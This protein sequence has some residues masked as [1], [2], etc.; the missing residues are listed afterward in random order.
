MPS[1]EHIMALWRLH[2]PE[3][4][5]RL[6]AKYFQNAADWFCYGKIQKTFDHCL[7]LSY[8]K[9][10]DRPG[11]SYYRNAYSERHDVLVIDDPWCFAPT[12]DWLMLLYARYWYDH[13]RET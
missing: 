10:H 1:D 7:V 4:A 2:K 12:K 5:T 11:I 3:V 8:D 13:L 6:S 9:I